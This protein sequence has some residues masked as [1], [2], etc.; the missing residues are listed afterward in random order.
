MVLLSQ[1]EKDLS[2]GRTVAGS[3]SQGPVVSVA[4]SRP[5]ASDPFDRHSILLP[6]G[7][8]DVR[9][10]ASRRSGPRTGPS[11][12]ERRRRAPRRPAVV[13]NR[14]PTNASPS[15]TN[16]GYRIDCCRQ[17]THR[18]ALCASRRW[19]PPAPRTV[20][21]AGSRSREAILPIRRSNATGGTRNFGPSFISGIE[22]SE[23]SASPVSK[24]VET[25]TRFAFT[26]L[27]D[28]TN[29]FFVTS[30]R[31][32]M[33]PATVENTPMCFGVDVERERVAVGQP[34]RFGRHGGLGGRDDRDGVSSVGTFATERRRRGRRRCG[35][36]RRGACRRG[37]GRGSPRHRPPGRA[38]TGRACGSRCRCPRRAAACPRRSGSCA[39]R[40][41]GACSGCDRGP[42]RPPSR[43]PSSRPAR[44]SGRSAAIRTAPACARPADA[45]G[46]RTTAAAIAATRQRKRARRRQAHAG[47]R[48]A[49]PT[50][51]AAP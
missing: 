14:R 12:G 24:T 50:T 27:N 16:I 51:P 2:V 32:L 44:R 21:G 7:H 29:G 41:A 1:V 35:P 30:G 36:G 39:G 47:S 38:A 5:S 3:A 45:R 34:G 46:A 48:S 4:M 33:R 13:V 11:T 25:K 26:Y 37:T 20:P 22:M 23:I 10:T 40:E 18:R 43:R 19:L 8:D 49:A 17:A 15:G 6:C 42:P 28:V 31:I 9:T